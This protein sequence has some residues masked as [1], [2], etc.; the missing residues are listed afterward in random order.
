LKEC[1]FDPSNIKVL[2]YLEI[3]YNI[4]KTLNNYIAEFKKI[5]EN[6]YNLRNYKSQLKLHVNY[7]DII[8]ISKNT[9]KT[10]IIVSVVLCETI[11][12]IS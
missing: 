6:I 8:L 11:Y 7:T 1:I 5:F 2:R 10:E 12:Y 3:K 4:F 9:K